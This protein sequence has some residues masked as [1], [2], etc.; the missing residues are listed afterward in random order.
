MPLRILSRDRK[1]DF[2]VFSFLVLRNYGPPSGLSVDAR[3]HGFD[4]LFETLLSEH[5]L[6]SVLGGSFHHSNDVSLLFFTIVNKAVYHRKL[7][8]CYIRLFPLVKL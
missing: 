6:E 4:G 7:L 3:V 1:N 2:L 5:Q 8:I